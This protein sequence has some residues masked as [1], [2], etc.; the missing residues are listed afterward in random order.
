MLIVYW[1][2]H[3]DFDP[4]PGWWISIQMPRPWLDLPLNAALVQTWGFGEGVVGQAW[5]VSAEVAAYLAFP[6]LARG[7]SGNSRPSTLLLVVVGVAVTLVA[8]QQIGSRDGQY[9]AGAFDIWNGPPAVMRCLAGFTLGLCLCRLSES[10][11]GRL[12]HSDLF[13][14]CAIGLWLFML[15][16]AAPDLLLYIPFGALVLC[17]SKNRG[18]LGA[19]FG[20]LPLY[21]MGLLSYSFYLIHVY[22][23]PPMHALANF[24]API[25][26]AGYAEIV[27]MTITMSALLVCS[28]VAYLAVERPARN[29]LRRSRVA[30]FKARPVRNSKGQEQHY[31]V[32]DHKV[33]SV[34]RAG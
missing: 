27:A 19:V 20:S 4:H 13:G 32:D 14:L 10:R 31:Q 21:R 28:G 22:F 30:G 29:L 7:I 12:L 25:T 3:H 1:L 8:A 17:L 9:H 24:L 26:S 18:K 2:V 5:S 33:A 11:Y 34:V 16:W 15:V 23:I 6:W